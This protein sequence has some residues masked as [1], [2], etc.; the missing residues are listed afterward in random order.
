MGCQAFKPLQGLSF[1]VLLVFYL[2][3][4]TT[5]ITNI[6]LGLFTISRLIFIR[7]KKELHPTDNLYFR[8][9]NRK[10]PFL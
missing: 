2:A 3:F 8:L 5:F 1:K 4:M 6:T 10:L 9:L 7:F